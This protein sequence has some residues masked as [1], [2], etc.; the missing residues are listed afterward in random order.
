MVVALTKKEIRLK[1]VEGLVR[2][3]DLEVSDQFI[4][5][6]TECVVISKKESIKFRSILGTSWKCSEYG[7]NCQMWVQKIN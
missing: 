5:M 2:L 4:F 1:Q 3:C 7:L 6:N